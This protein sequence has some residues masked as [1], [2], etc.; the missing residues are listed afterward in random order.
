MFETFDTPRLQARR[1]A[2][3]DLGYVILT[4]TDELMQRTLYGVLSTR[5]E[6]EQRLNRWLREEREV[7]MGF[8]I[9]SSGGEHIG[10]GGLFRSVRLKGEIE[11]GYALRPPYWGRGY[12][13][14][15]A[16]ALIETVA[17]GLELKHLIG[18]TIP[19]NVPSQRVLEKCGFSLTGEVPS[20][21][22]T[23]S[24]RYDLT[25]GV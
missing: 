25:L 23:P 18:V 12:A 19:D 14:E 3:T 22:G 9:F 7:Q 5:D 10:H 17:H 6:S 13:T 11:L 8:W 4:D 1:I 21:N 16:H 2:A 20:P 15:M 24:L